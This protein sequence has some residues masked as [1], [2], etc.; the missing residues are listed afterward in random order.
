MG[1]TITLTI[2]F[3]ITSKELLMIKYIFVET[4]TFKLISFNQLG[5]LTK[6]TKPYFATKVRL[7]TQSHL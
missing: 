7:G 4:L 3:L 2:F 5:D 1:S 6:F